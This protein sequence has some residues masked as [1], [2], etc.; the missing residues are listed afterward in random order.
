LFS[1]RS[2]IELGAVLGT[3]RRYK[4]SSLGLKP[5]DLHLALSKGRRL[6]LLT[7]SSSELDEFFESLDR[8]GCY[9]VAVVPQD[10]FEPPYPGLIP[11]DARSDQKPLRKISLEQY[12][13]KAAA[14]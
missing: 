5:K 3:R 4:E 9:H 10:D 7:R 13:S 12:L 6:T 2:G 1:W 11:I 8:V 14:A